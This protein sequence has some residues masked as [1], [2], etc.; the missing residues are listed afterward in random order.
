MNT[1]RKFARVL[2]TRDVV[3][4]SFGAMIG[5]SWVLFSG[6]WIASGGSLG[7][8]IAFLVGGAVV[9][10]IGL[11]YAELASAMPKVGGEHV[12]THRALGHGPSFICTWALLM[13]YVMVCVFESAA[14]P[15]ALEYLVPAIRFMPLWEIQ[16]AQVN[17]G[18]VTVG[19]AGALTMTWVNVRGIRTA[20]IVQSIITLLIFLSGA[21]LMIGA[22]SFGDLDR[23]TPWFANG[24]PGIGVVL[25]MVP[26]LLVGFDVI[27]QSAEEIDLEPGRIGMLL[28]VSVLCA[29]GWYAMITLSVAVGTGA[30]SDD[31]LATADAAATLWGSG[32][33]GQ[34]LVIGGVGGILTSWNAFIIGA[35]RLMFALAESGVLPSC[36]AQ[37][38]PR[39]RTPYVAIVTLG[40]L[41]CVSPL[42]GRSILVWLVNAGSFA[43]VI[44]YLFVA[45]AFVA[46]RRNEPDMPRPFRV[47]MGIP[48]GIVTI[49]ASL[50]LLNVYLPWSPSGLLWPNEWLM[51]IGWA[52]LGALVFVRS[53]SHAA[54]S[55]GHHT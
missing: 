12:Y 54:A 24:A 55:R 4:L 11:L 26:A 29:V 28:V 10:L 2:R 23:A 14:L 49:V 1:N 21:L 41:S 31:S 34:F 8:A 16:G 53:S 18:F 36:F 15:T 5:W 7:A 20:A 9:A 48:V 27:P 40:A 17:F 37:L 3:L 25:I 47:R 45:I 50:L 33:A 46:L 32:L 6:H 43:V 52:A 39:Y 19:I 51:V 35:S 22:I 30:V 13:S 42:F 44:A 38:H